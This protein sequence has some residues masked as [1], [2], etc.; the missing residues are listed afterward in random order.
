MT[1]LMQDCT[2]ASAGCSIAA[3]LLPKA[4]VQT[5]QAL[6]LVWRELKGILWF[7][8]NEKLAQ[9]TSLL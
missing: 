1:D 5:D 8:R 7:S 4:L 3:Q 2:H 9:M 6:L